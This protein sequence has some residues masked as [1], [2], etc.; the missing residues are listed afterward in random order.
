MYARPQLASS[1]NSIL[2]HPSLLKKKVLH[3]NIS[4]SLTFSIHYYERKK[5]YKE[6]IS[7]DGATISNRKETAETAWKELVW[8]VNEKAGI[9]LRLSIVYCATC[10][11]FYGFI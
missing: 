3:F 11:L 7:T 6:K 10:Y 1:A 2:T 8:I 4:F 5:N 9:L